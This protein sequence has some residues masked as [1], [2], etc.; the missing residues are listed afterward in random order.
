MARHCKSS[1]S[2]RDLTAFDPLTPSQ[3]HQFDPRVNIFSVSWSTA[4]PLLFNMPH[5]HVQ[6]IKFLTPS[7]PKWGMTQATEWKSCLICFMSFI[8]EKRKRHKVWFNNLWNWHLMIFDHLVPP[9]GPRERGPKNGAIACAIQ[10]SNSHTKSGWISENI[11]L[12]PPPPPTV[13]QVPSLGHDPGDRM[14]SHLISY[15]FHL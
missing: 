13:P 6:N 3:G 12:P 1:R 4:H 2:R 15:I 14:K 10:V 7:T 8:C 5:A 11:F 9:Q